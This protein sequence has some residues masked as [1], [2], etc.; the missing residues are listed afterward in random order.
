MKRIAPQRQNGFTIIEIMIALALGVLLSSALVQVFSSSRQMASMETSLSRLQETGRFAMGAIAKD[1]RMAG[2]QGCADPNDLDITVLAKKFDDE[3][4]NFASIVGYETSTTGAF[5]PALSATDVIRDI[6]MTSASG[7]YARPGTDVVSITFANTTDAELAA[8]TKSGNVKVSENPTGL[9]QDDF[10]IVSDCKSAHLFEITNVTGGG[11]TTI[12]F[13]HAIAASGDN[14]NGAGNVHNK[15]EPPYSA[16]AKLMSFENRTYF[17]A[18]TERATQ[19]GKPVYSLYVREFDKDPQEI[20]EG[21]ESL[22]LLYG[23]QLASGKIRYVKADDADMDWGEV[24]SVRIGLLIQSFSQVADDND[25]RSYELPGATISHT[26]LGK[27][28][29][30]RA[31]RRPFT[32]TVKLRNRRQ[33]L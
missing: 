27:H 21:V 29:G 11:G 26:G 25:T 22:Q 23:Q 3:T 19:F 32:A 15:L 7:K 20:L 28:A 4:L 13:T 31:L 16:G 30:D 5:S 8:S 14:N 33:Q 1:I 24:V 18:D 12:N 10:A 6:Q 9:S 2:Y 17:V